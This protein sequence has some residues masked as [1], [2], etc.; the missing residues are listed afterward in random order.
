MPGWE[1]AVLRC[2]CCPLND[3]KRSNYILRFIYFYVTLQRLSSALF[4][5]SLAGITPVKLLLKGAFPLCALWA[6]KAL[7]FILLQWMKAWKIFTS[8]WFVQS[9]KL[10]VANGRF[11][12]IRRIQYLLIARWSFWSLSKIQKTSEIPTLCGIWAQRLFFC[13]HSLQKL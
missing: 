10:T 4:A 3:L 1:R 13:R 5:V 9:L 6:I 2:I 11:I 7:F 12:F 8:H